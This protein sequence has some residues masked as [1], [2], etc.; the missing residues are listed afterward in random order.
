MR[1]LTILYDS[2]CGFCVRCRRWMDAQ[3]AFLELEFLPAASRA[4]A[5]RFPTL[6]LSGDDLVAVDDEGGVY[7]GPDAF[8]MC[9][10]ALREHRELSMRL[11]SPALRPLARLSFALLSEGR[12][13]L[14]RWLGMA[15][16]EE[17]VE[18]LRRAGSPECEAG[19]PQVVDGVRVSLTDAA[20]GVCSK[21]LRDRVVAC[22]KCLAPHHPECWVYAGRCS[23]Y[24]CG[25][26]VYRRLRRAV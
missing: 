21:P 15:S 18:T 24:G 8:L 3:P 12:R 4:A 6:S 14:G 17:I 9:L 22:R 10:Y 11:A 25:S 5:D 19:E 2:S 7:R 23:T 20:C 16:E 13:R 1:R 26:V